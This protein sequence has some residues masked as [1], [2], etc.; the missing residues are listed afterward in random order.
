MTTSAKDTLRAQL[1]HARRTRS[2]EQ[3][4]EDNKA[5]C[6]G[7]RALLTPEMTVAAYYPLGTEPGGSEFVETI[8]AACA[9]VYLPISAPKGLLLWTRYDGPDSMRPGALGIAE[10][11]GERH[12]SAILATVDLILAP[13]MAVSPSGMRL[14]KG[15]GYYDRALSPLP[16]GHPPVVALVHSTEVR[17]VPFEKHDRPVDGILTEREMHWI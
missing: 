8:K 5:W 6:K 17:E 12:S 2:A 14:G 3:R 11:Q 9:E 16:T 4:A 13:A 7:V 10:P 15:A 1:L